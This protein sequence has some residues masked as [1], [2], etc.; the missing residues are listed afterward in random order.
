MRERRTKNPSARQAAVN[1]Q[2]EAKLAAKPPP[3]KPAQ[4]LAVSLGAASAAR[5]EIKTA[6]KSPPSAAEVITQEEMKALKKIQRQRTI[7]AADKAR[8]DA[9]AGIILY[10]RN[11]DLPNSHHHLERRKRLKTAV[12]SKRQRSTEDDTDPDESPFMPSESPTKR[13]K[14]GEPQESDAESFNELDIH[15]SNDEGAAPTSGISLQLQFPNNNLTF[16]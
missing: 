2:Q 5:K 16:K 1:A 14:K 15:V 7:I 13:M 6:K 11:P 9:D 3:R 8:D 4:S 10:F 12:N